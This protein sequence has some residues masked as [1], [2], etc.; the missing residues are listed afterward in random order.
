MA[1][2]QPPAPGQNQPGSTQSQKSATDLK[3]TLKEILRLEG[4]YRDILRDSV[5][6]LQA[7]LKNYDRMEAKLATINKSRLN[8]KEIE[9]QIKKTTEDSYTN[10]KKLA[11]MEAKLSDAGKKKAKDFNDQIVAVQQK[12]ES[13]RNARLA[14]DKALEAQLANELKYEEGFLDLLKDDLN[15]EELKFAQLLKT[16]ELNQEILNRQKAQLDTENKI[17]DSIGITGKM[18]GFVAD[19]LGVGSKF[20]EKMVQKAREQNGE[21][22]LTQ[23]ASLLWKSTTESISEYFDK[24]KKDPG[25]ILVGISAIGK[26][27]GDM[28]KGAANSVASFQEMS[29][30]KVIGKLASGISSIVS[31]IPYVGGLI[32]GLVEGFAKLLELALAADDKIVKMGRNLGISKEQATALNDKYLKMSLNIG[33]NLMSQRKLVESH[34]EIVGLLGVTNTLTESIVKDNLELSKL[35]GLD[36]KTRGSIAESS[37][38]TGRESKEITKSVLGQVAGLKMATGISFEYKKILA[39]ASN[40]SGVLGLQFAKYPDKLSKALVET[41]AMGLEL[42]K[43]NSMA[44]SF[45]NFEQSLSK[46]FEAQLITG[47]D[48]NL[49]KAREAFLNNDLATAASEISKYAGSANDFLKMNRIEQEALSGA[50][51]MSRDDLADM[52]KKQEML[53]KLGAKDLKEAQAKVEALK[54]QGK[55]RQEIIDMVG[56]EAYRNLTNMSVQEKIAGFVEKIQDAVST[57]LSK[58]PIIPLV[59]Q[60]IDFLSKPES[61]TII[62][63]K[64][65]SVFATLFD[66]MGAVVGAIMEVGNFFGAGIDDKLIR[67][68][69]KGGAPIRAMNLTGGAEVGNAAA[70]N[71]AGGSSGALSGGSNS[72]GASQP[73]VVQFNVNAVLDDNYR[74]NSGRMKMAAKM[75]YNTGAFGK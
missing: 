52:L 15:I 73:S 9:A 43:L 55:T 18:F 53:S 25:A 74:T 75:G 38:I 51:G 69:K 67:M 66:I 29:G 31:K 72:S 5:K 61:I 47:K 40:F 2:N 8:I 58:S 34:Q 17:K 4:D 32:A 21:L 28:A 37:I 48:I 49:T 1:T 14:G 24:L 70:Q 12:E 54:A 62:V 41:K 60:A 11:D 16:N 23:K 57:F 71:E 64:I 68:V 44:D 27:M 13:L 30:D 10:T 19:K 46:E 7:T 20:Y 56:E 45:L 50:M 26:K 42:G 33:S 65:Q 6:E 39:E 35:M 63:T 36:A 22:T 59:E 3:D